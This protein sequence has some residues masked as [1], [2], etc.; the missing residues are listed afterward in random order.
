MI[1]KINF[2]LKKKQFMSLSP[3]A[4][5]KNGIFLIDEEK[6]FYELN[7]YLQKQYL[8]ILYPMS[9]MPTVSCVYIM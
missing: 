3:L 2:F 9:A 7:I 5:E 1:N 4:A 8:A 6:S